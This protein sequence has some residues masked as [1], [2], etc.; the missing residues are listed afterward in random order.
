MVVM[1]PC[2]ND[3]DAVRLLLRELENSFNSINLRS[4]VLLVDDCSSTAEPENL[5]NGPFHALSSIEVLKLRRNMGH[6]RAICIG[7]SYIYEHRDADVVLVMDADGE[8]QPSD[9]VRMLSV[10][11]EQRRTAIVFAE[12]TRRSEDLI[13]RTGY[14]IYRILHQAL[15]G[16]SVKVGNFSIIPREHLASLVV[17][18]ELWSH[19]AASVF[20]SK[21]RHVGVPTT[22]GAR[23]AGKSKL[24]FVALVIHGLSAISV[25]LDVVGVRL[26][27]AVFAGSGYLILLCVAIV[28]LKFTTNMAIPGWATTTLGLLL[29]ILMQ[30]FVLILGLT[31]L[32]LFNRNN[33]SFIPIRDYKYFVGRIIGIFPPHE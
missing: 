26:S 13:F 3:W 9:I 22:R 10:F 17:I 25:F 31:G 2:Y 28:I 23:L 24:N 18:S 32:V 33:L 15:T 21:I 29:I 16:I 19:Y 11:E 8:D 20:R 4:E 6:Q 27:L 30:M 5:A 1:M 12:R 7:L 14:F